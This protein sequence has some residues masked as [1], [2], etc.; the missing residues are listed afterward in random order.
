M[1]AEKTRAEKEQEEVPQTLALMLA[2]L[3]GPPGTGNAALIEF[4]KISREVDELNALLKEKGCAIYPIGV[5]APR[6]LAI[7]TASNATGGSK[8]ATI[9]IAEKIADGHPWKVNM[10]E[11]KLEVEMTLFPDGSGV[12]NHL[13]VATAEWRPN[14]NGLCMKTSEQTR[15][16]CFTFLIRPSGY[17]AIEDGKLYL[18]FR[19]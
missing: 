13:D 19:R 11:R 2:R 15:E 9:S 7:V 5:D 6:F 14:V 10:V 17:D 16:H 4:Q 1:Q 12:A 3:S 8:D 18:E